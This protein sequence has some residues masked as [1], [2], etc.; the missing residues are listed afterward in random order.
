MGR[1]RLIL[2]A[3]V[4]SMA[5]ALAGCE[6]QATP[7][8]GAVATA[9]PT[10]APTSVA[11]IRY[12]LIQSLLFF[13]PNASALQQAGFVEQ[14]ANEDSEDYDVII[15]YG[16]RDGWQTAPQPLTVGLV[17]NPNLSPL[18]KPQVAQWVRQSLNT[19]GLVGETSWTA[20]TLPTLAPATIRTQ[21]V[22]AQ[23]PDGY[24]LVLAHTFTTTL[25]ALV[26]NF[27]ASNLEIET[28]AIHPDQLETLIANNQ[29]HLILV[30]WA[31]ESVKNA[32]I[33][34]VG[35]ENVL[36]LLQV[37]IR[38]R[39][40]SGIVVTGYTDDGLPIAERQP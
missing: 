7:V 2:W 21:M 8:A 33:A 14:T 16:T 25:D 31:N 30:A 28:R 23:T 6:A 29:A 13:S 40:A 9:T 15:G 37:P 39:L 11:P 10:L 18:D 34:Q 35:D 24:K 27:S 26:S 19:N 38:Y 4:A 17:I 1:A 20:I 32:W 22:Q 12:A 36:A 3:F 5:I